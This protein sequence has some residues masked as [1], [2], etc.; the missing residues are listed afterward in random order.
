MWEIMTNMATLLFVE[1]RVASELGKERMW[2]IY[3]HY[4]YK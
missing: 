1:P 2:E 4:G 3:D